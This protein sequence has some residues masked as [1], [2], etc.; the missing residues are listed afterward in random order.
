MKYTDRMFVF[1]MVYIFLI[2]RL[3]Q[4]PKAAVKGQ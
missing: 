2:K 4:A 3:S 1:Q